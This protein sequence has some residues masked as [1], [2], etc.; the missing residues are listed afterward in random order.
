M[1]LDPDRTAQRTE[2]G[3]PGTRDKGLPIAPRL[4][5]LQLLV[6]NVSALKVVLD[7]TKVEIV[8]SSFWFYVSH[9]FFYD[10]F[11]FYLYFEHHK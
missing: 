2:R 7:F 1:A 9:V 11:L 8:E 5:L 10:T 6:Q 4:M 3:V